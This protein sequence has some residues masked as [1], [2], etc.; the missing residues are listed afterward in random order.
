MKLSD[1]HDL[2]VSEARYSFETVILEDGEGPRWKFSYDNWHRDPEPDILLLGAFRHPNTNNNLVGGINLHY[3]NQ[4]Q[5][6]RLARSLPAIMKSNSLKRRYWV[7]RQL[8]PDVFNNFYRTYNAQYIRGVTKD[9]M[10]PKYGYIKTAQDWLKKKLTSIFKPKRQREQENLPQYPDDLQ[11]MQDRLDQAVN[12]LATDQ[13]EPDDTPE[14]QAATRAFQD[15]QRQ[16]TIKQLE[17]HEDEPMQQA[18]REM[19]RA[20]TTPGMQDAERNAGRQEIAPEPEIQKP[21]SVS[22][23]P[24]PTAQELN[25][26]KQR[27]AANN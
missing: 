9:V 19:D 2:A 13:E 1:A 18:Q 10:Y 8:V 17:R 6:D 4:D 7:G 5:R 22:P 24:P 20:I 21:T 26:I 12:D 27:E 15:F 23:P 14:M 16:R 11:S 3:I 25:Q